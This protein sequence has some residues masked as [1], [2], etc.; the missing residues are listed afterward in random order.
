MKLKTK[1][2]A[3]QQIQKIKNDFLEKYNIGEIDN[4]VVVI[5][6]TGDFNFESLSDNH[7]HLDNKP[8]LHSTASGVK[9][10]LVSQWI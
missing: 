5:N 1:V 9:V 6:P 3:L 8:V 2:N 4:L 10:G 7:K